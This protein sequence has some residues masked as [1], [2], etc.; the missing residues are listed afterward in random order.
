[1]RKTLH[2]SI[3]LCL[4]A[5]LALIA[6]CHHRQRVVYTPPPPDYYRPPQHLGHSTTA[7]DYSEPTPVPDRVEGK[8]L[9]E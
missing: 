3:Q 7:H 1:M 4:L 9:S 5:S 6:G 2:N 8:P